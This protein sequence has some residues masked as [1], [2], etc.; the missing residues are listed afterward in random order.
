MGIVS[1]FK[2]LRARED[3]IAIE[4]VEEAQYDTREERYA[5]SSDP[6]TVKADQEASRAVH[7]PNIEDLERFAEDDD[8]P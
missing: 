8:G 6:G 4:R 3:E 7:E 5:T 1:W 2:K